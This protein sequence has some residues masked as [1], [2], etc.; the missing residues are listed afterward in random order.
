MA[1]L[2]RQDACGWTAVG[3]DGLR[4]RFDLGATE[5][6]PDDGGVAGFVAREASVILRSTEGLLGCAWLLAAPSGNDVVVNGERVHAGLIVLADRDEILLADGER[7]FFSTAEV[8]T[9][10]PIDAPPPGL[11]C[12]RCCRSFAAGAPVVRCPGP[13]CGVIHHQ[14]DDL[15]CWTYTGRCAVC[16][17]STELHEEYRWTPEGL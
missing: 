5:R 10:E 15:P 4:A 3:L 1:R 8:A 2:W 14:T 16:P 13:G 11:R 12:P 6:A 9:V 17:Q 7:L